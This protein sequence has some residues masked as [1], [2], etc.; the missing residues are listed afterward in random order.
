MGM[1]AYCRKYVFMSEEMIDKKIFPKDKE[2]SIYQE[3]FQHD[4]IYS[5]ELL[6]DKNY[7]LH[8]ETG[9][10]SYLQ[11]IMQLASYLLCE[12]FVC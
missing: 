9:Q 4:L 3:S 1:K 5:S 7:H 6:W 11:G 10:I 12:L 8:P 2:I